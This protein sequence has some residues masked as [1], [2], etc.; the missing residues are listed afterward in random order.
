MW[1][2]SGQSRWLPTGFYGHLETCKRR[3]S[4]DLLVSLTPSIECGWCVLRDFN[5]IVSQDEKQGGVKEQNLR[6]RF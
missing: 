2:G 6:W 3:E 5:E 1:E 4:W